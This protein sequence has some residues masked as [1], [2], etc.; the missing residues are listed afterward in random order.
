M[1]VGIGLGQIIAG[2]Q[3][4]T[5]PRGM[6]I[7]AAKQGKDS[8]DGGDMY[9]SPRGKALGTCMGEWG[10]F[11]R[12]GYEPVC[13]AN[14]DCDQ[15]HAAWSVGASTDGEKVV[16]VTADNAHSQCRVQ[17]LD[18]SDPSDPTP[19]S[20]FST[21]HP[22]GCEY[23]GGLV[24][25]PCNLALIIVNPP[26]DQTEGGQIANSSSPSPSP[27]LFAS[28][29]SSPS[30]SPSSSP[31]VSPSSSASASPSSSPSSSA[32]ASPSSSPSES[33]SS[34]E[35]ASPSSASASP[36][37]SESASPSSSPSASPSSSLSAS[38]SSS[39]PPPSVS[40]SRT[41]TKSPQF[42]PAAAEWDDPN[43]NRR[44]LTD[45]A[46]GNSYLW[47]LDLAG[48]AVV[49]SNGQAFYIDLGTGQPI[50]ISLSADGHTAVV[51]M[52]TDTGGYYMVVDMPDCA[53]VATWIPSAHYTFSGTP[54]FVAVNKDE[55]VITL[56]G[57]NLLLVNLKTYS[58]ST[59]GAG[60][61]T[62]EGVDATTN[63]M[64]HPSET[65]VDESR[66]PYGVT[67]LPNGYFVT[68]NE[69][70]RGWSVY[71]AAGAVVFDI[72]A[73]L[74]Q[75]AINIGL[76]PESEAGDAGIAPET[77]LYACYPDQSYG[78]AIKMRALEA[79]AS[80][81]LKVA[82]QGKSTKTS[83]TSRPLTST[84]AGTKSAS[85]LT[86]ARSMQRKS[87]RAKCDGTEYLFVTATK[88]HFIAVYEIDGGSFKLVQTLPTL[89]GPC[90]DCKATGPSGL[91]AI[92]ERGLLVAGTQTP[93]GMDKASVVVWKLGGNNCL[94][95]PVCDQSDR[96]DG[97]DRRDSSDRRDGRDSYS[98][99]TRR[100][101][102]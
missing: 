34:S 15:D 73:S 89:T 57:N 38:T 76:F 94:S 100:I 101:Q 74:E 37:S 33:P 23:S 32:S 70:S 87:P 36:S 17:V 67:Y 92:P 4:K 21:M 62:L 75:T 96:S 81:E 40:R 60:S 6:N 48:N 42:A 12:V 26:K 11:H 54:K 24:V 43:K 22:Y 71:D 9:A 29:S 16:Y 61:V 30:E 95:N 90:E 93:G 2:P 20:P 83:S 91:V 68:A 86:K 1:G 46:D 59:V 27:S 98:R 5:Q 66:L 84:T 82:S 88:A 99:R 45:L 72:G 3:T 80:E 19:D 78:K 47:A 77:V 10:Q 63:G 8:S 85:T 50:A 56:N 49:Q 31:S 79:M 51:V 97:R 55:A 44:R 58:S 35:S 53:N 13:M 41:P 7:L 52:E 64:V 14:G 18:I 102:G 39:P 65:I 25:N 28:P 69:G